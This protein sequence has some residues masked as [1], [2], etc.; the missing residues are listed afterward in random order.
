VLSKVHGAEKGI[1]ALK[2]IKDNNIKTYYLFYV[3]KAEFYMEMNQLKEAFE[4]FEIAIP[5]TPL[6]K[7]KKLLQKRLES[8]LQRNS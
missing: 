1:S 4:N 8:C 3:T 5:I 2:Q 6:Q 7:E